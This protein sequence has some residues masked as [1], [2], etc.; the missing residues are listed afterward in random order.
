M[1]LLTQKTLDA[2]QQ[3]LARALKTVRGVAAVANKAA[4]ELCAGGSDQSSHDV[5]MLAAD[6]ETIAADLS[7]VYR[8]ARLLSIDLPDGGA[9]TAAR[10]D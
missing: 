10:K 3:A 8:R 1:T 2:Q 5:G 6:L 4:D 9:L 7:R